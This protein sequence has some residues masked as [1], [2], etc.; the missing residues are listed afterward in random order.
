MKKALLA[1]ILFLGMLFCIPVFAHAERINSFSSSIIIGQTSVMVTEEISYNFE[2][3]L[4]HGIYRDIPLRNRD[5]SF[6]DIENISVTNQAGQSVPFI[7]ENQ[8]TTLHIKIGDAHTLITGTQVYRI[9]YTVTNAMVAYPEFDELYWNATGNKWQV[10]IDQAMVNVTYDESFPSDSVVRSA[11]YYGRE[12]S[13][14]SCVI[15]TISGQPQQ[16]RATQ[17]NLN[18]GEGVSVAIGIKKGVITIPERTGST[19]SNATDRSSKGKDLL[20]KVALILGLTLVVLLIARWFEVYLRGYRGVI[21]PEYEPPQGLTPIQVGTIVDGTTDGSDITAT[22]ISLAERGCVTIEYIEQQGFLVNQTDYRFTFVKKPDTADVVDQM[23]L[24]TLFIVPNPEPGASRTAKEI[25]GFGQGISSL[26]LNTQMMRKKLIQNIKGA[27]FD[28]LVER[29]LVMRKRLPIM[30]QIGLAV[31][32]L[33]IVVTFMLLAQGSE[34]GYL[35]FIVSIW[36]VLMH[37]ATR[38]MVTPEGRA[39]MGHIKG[40]K[41]FLSV[42]DRDRFDFHNAPERK[43]ETFMKYLP[44]AIALGVENKWAKQFD[45]ITIPEPNWYHGRPGTF[46]AMSFTHQLGMMNAAVSG[47]AGNRSASGGGGFSGGG[48]GG[49]GGGSW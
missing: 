22:I 26:F 12:Y 14:N 18:P 15:Q 13:N 45:G 28:Q 25:Q 8:G 3:A 30:S 34:L 46:S 49:G 24:E 21:I 23:V 35:G 16:L 31:T 36:F 19:D 11:C 1:T 48:S 5:G 47:F 38:T 10:P 37:G 20:E 41:W 7:Q 43:P 27:T 29:G 6:L 32:A 42:T 44:Y 4:R 17:K 2:D 9:A 39:V 40:F 33:L